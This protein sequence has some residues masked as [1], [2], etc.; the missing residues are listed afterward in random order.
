[1]HTYALWPI[2][3]PILAGAPEPDCIDVIIQDVPARFDTY[4]RYHSLD[5]IVRG[6]IR[7]E[8]D[9]KAPLLREEHWKICGLTGRRL[10]AWAWVDHAGNER[11]RCKDPHHEACAPDLEDPTRARLARMNARTLRLPLPSRRLLAHPMGPSS[12]PMGPSSAPG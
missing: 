12:A 3:L 2:L 4:L 7:F 11:I 9:P 8:P 5:R 1:M 10:L 6:T